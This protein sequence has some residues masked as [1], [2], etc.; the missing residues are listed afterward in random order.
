MDNT[1]ELAF[2]LNPNSE[3][4]DVAKMKEEIDRYI[5]SNGGVISFAKEP[6]KIRLS[7]PVKKHTMAYFGYFHFKSEKPEQIKQIQE[8]V[9]SNPSV[10]RFLLIKFD[11]DSSRQ[12]DIIKRMASAEKA[13]KSRAAAQKDESAKAGEPPVKEEELEKELEK[14]I[15]KL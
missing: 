12:Q 4:A 5:T 10:I 3:E 11:V 13:R 6:E 1:Y 14:I 8:L 2:H 15:D 9:T 7:Y